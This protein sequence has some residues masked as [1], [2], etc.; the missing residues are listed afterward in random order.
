M[1]VKVLVA[2]LFL[3]LCDPMDCSN[4]APLS[5]EFP[6]QEYCSGLPFPSSGDFSDS[7]IEYGS[8]ALQEDSLLSELPGK[9][10]GREGTDK[11]SDFLCKDY[12]ISNLAV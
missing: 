5:V 8:P 10:R 7:G 2:Q 12:C 3:T 4:Q 6:R 9:P 1:K 11:M